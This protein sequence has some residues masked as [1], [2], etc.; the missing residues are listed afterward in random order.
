MNAPESVGVT[1]GPTLPQGLGLHMDDIEILDLS[2]VKLKL[3]DSEEGTGWTVEKC[4]AVEID[5]KRFL[6]LKRAYPDREIVPNREVDH[7]WHQHI[8][9]TERY[10][11]DCEA[12]FG[13]FLHHYPYFGMRGE[14]DYANLCTAFSETQ[15]LY[16]RHFG[17]KG[18]VS[19]SAKCRTKC[20]PVKCK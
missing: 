10:A 11:E 16:E 2:M 5:Y 7:F 1:A 14:D 9:D 17:G 19:A 12:L 3:Q 18:G 15:A 13:V 4:D 8:L 20:K 6:A